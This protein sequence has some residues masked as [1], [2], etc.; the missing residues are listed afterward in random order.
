MTAL[1]AD[2]Q[3]AGFGLYVHWPFCQSKC[4]YCDFNSHVAAQIDHDAWNRAYLGEIERIG[5][6]TPGRNLRSIYFGGGTPSLMRPQ[7]IE[8]IIAAAQQVWQFDNDIEITLEANPS[9]VELSRFRAYQLAG[10]NRVS[11]GVQA[12]DTDDLRALGRLHS[13]AEA[14]AAIATA[15]TVFGRYS[16][17]LIYAR[18]NQTLQG[19]RDELAGA[20]ELRADHMSLYQLTI[21]PGTAFGDRFALGKLPGLPVEDLAADMFELTQEMMISAGLE[22]YEVSNHARPGHASRHN[23]IYWNGGDYA[24]IGPGAHGRLTLDARRYAT[25]TPLAPARWL[26]MASAGAAENPM[27]PLSSIDQAN[28]AL[29]MGLRTAQGVQLAR[30]NALQNE[31]FFRKINELADFGVIELSAT[32]LRATQAG[33][34][35]LNELLRQLMVA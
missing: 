26:E 29:M 25:D 11:L 31:D 7:T 30:I 35:I 19:W 32:H 20:L 3:D 33:R 14:R 27:Q 28:E 13:V 12:L 8:A 16:F 5:A 9:S 1:S 18:Q 23:L 2:W 34:P 22:P 4:P 10:V 24:G 6:F 15:A 17:D 21:E